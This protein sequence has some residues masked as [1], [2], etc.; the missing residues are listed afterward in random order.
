[1]D[2]P[3]TL[4]V[5]AYPG[6]TL[7]RPEIEAGMSTEDVI[8]AAA[9]TIS[10]PAE[11]AVPVQFL[12]VAETSGV[13]LHAFFRATATGIENSTDNVDGPHTVGV[14]AGTDITVTAG[15]AHVVTAPDGDDDVAGVTIKATDDIRKCVVCIVTSQGNDTGQ[16]TAVTVAGVAA[17]LVVTGGNT[18]QQTMW[19]A[20]LTGSQ[21]ATGTIRVQTS[22]VSN[23]FI[24]HTAILEDAGTVA[25][26]A[27][28]FLSGTSLNV[29]GLS[30]PAGGAAVVFGYATRS[31]STVT[32]T[33]SG[34]MTAALS[35]NTGG[36]GD[37]HL[38]ARTGVLAY[39]AADDVT[40]TLTRSTSHWMR[41][42]AAT[43]S[44]A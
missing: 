42:I 36:T 39:A 24:L 37:A 26:T 21:A 10:T 16:V 44:K 11:V 27:A 20:D 18:N 32:L 33:L 30:V 28:Q 22:G 38:I 8:K 25:D 19:V 3:G 6:D 43:W 9:I 15:S 17:T 34:D 41:Y 7:T 2:Q 13:Y 40:A 35:S 29:A 12:D 5:A 4:F 1:V 14:A 31:T 23:R